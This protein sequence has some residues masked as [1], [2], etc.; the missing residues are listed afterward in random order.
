MKTILFANGTSVEYVQRIEDSDY[1]QGADRSILEFRFDPTKMTLDQIDKLFTTEGCARLRLSETYTI[2][3]PVYEDHRRGR[4]AG[5]KG[6]AG[7]RR[8]PTGRSRPGYISVHA[9]GGIQPEYTAQG[10][11]GHGS[12]V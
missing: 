8:F 1:I 5:Q 10:P 4:Q 3:V 12:A 2:P 9:C 7:P 11:V 6:E